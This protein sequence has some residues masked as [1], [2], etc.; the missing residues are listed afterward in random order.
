[1]EIPP[2]SLEEERRKARENWLRLRQQNF[3]S[4]N[5][6]RPQRDASQQSGNDLN[7]SPEDDS[8]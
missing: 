5:D 2:F 4:A 6:A 7:P 3:Y 8:E 1:V